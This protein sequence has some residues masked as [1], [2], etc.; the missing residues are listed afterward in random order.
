MGVV[1]IFFIALIFFLLRGPYLSNSIKRLIQP[2][3]ED[4][5]GEKIIIDKAVINLFP[6]YLQT[7]GLK[8]FDEEGNRL[9]WVTKMR[10]Y[11]DVLRL[12]SRE[13]RVRRLTV[14]EPNLTIG[15]ERLEKILDSVRGYAGDDNG[16]NF[17]VSLKAAKITDGEFTLIER[18]RQV[19]ISGSGL[20]I[21]VVVKNTIDVELSVKDVTLK[22]PDLSELDAGF[23][24]RMKLSDKK[25]KIL[26]AKIYSSDSTLETKGEMQ[27]SP[28]GAVEHGT[29]S[30]KASIL[31]KTI[32]EVFG[33]KEKGDGELSFSGSIDLAP[34]FKFNLKTKGWFYLQTLMELLKVK[35]DVTGRMSFDGEI[36]GIYPHVL[37]KGT[38]RLKNALLGGLHLNDVNGELRY[39]DKKFSLEDF[40]AHTYRGKLRGNAF[41]LIPSPHESI[42]TGEYYVDAYAENIDS[43]QF[44]KF[45]KWEPPFPEGK[46]KG[47]FRLNKKPNRRMELVAETTY[48]NTSK[49]GIFLNER[50]G[51]I[52]ADIDMRE[53]ILTFDR[54]I[55]S[56]SASEL[57]LSGSID[58]NKEKLNI[59]IELDSRDALDLTSPYFKGLKAPVKF[60]GKAKGHSKEPEISG[61][62]KVGPG[63][64]NGEPFTE[65]SGD[66]TYSPRSLSVKALRIKYGESVYEIFGSIDFRKTVGLFSFEAPYYRGNAV[67]KNGDAES[68]IAAV[69]KKLPITGFISGRVS[70]E[71]DKEKF[72][73]DVNITLEDSVVFT[74][75][76]DRMVIEAGLSPEKIT[77]SSIEAHRDKS[78]LNARGAVYFDGR[79]DALISSNSINLRDLA[80]LNKYPVGTTRSRVDANFSLDMKGS[81][82]FK[83]PHMKFSIKIS[84][85][86]FKDFLIGE[87]YIEGE[88]KDKRLSAKG[89][90]LIGDSYGKGMIA[91]DAGIFFSDILLWDINMEFK[92]GRYDFLLA[93]FLKDV[94]EDLSASLEGNI[95]LKG[96]KNKFSMDS[97][98]S[99]LSFSLYG[100]S[101]KN[102]GDIVLELTEDTFKIK[103]LSISGRNGDITATGAMKIGQ[104]YNLTIDGRIDLTPLK[105]LTKTIDFLKGDSDFAI[106]IFGHWKSPELKGEINIRDGAVMLA[107]LPYKIGSIDG[108]IFLDKDRITF[109]SF[110]AD[111]AGGRVVASGVGYLEGLSLKRLFVSSEMEGIRFRP[112]EDVDFAFDGK[113]FFET[114]PKRQSLIGDINIKKAKYEK[115]VEWKSWLLRLKEVKEVPLRQPSFLGKTTLN[116]HITGQDNILIDNNVARTPVKVD[117]NVQG[118]LAQY[119]LIGRIEAKGGTVFFR[120]NEFEIIEGSVDFV[121]TNRIVPVFHILAETFTSGYRI[122]LNLDGPA[123]RFALSLFSDPPL[124]E[125]DILALLTTG[126]ISKESKGFES[127]IGA[128]EATAFLTGRLQD[129]MEE[130]FKL[131]TGFERFEVNPQTTTTGAISP[132]ITVGKRLLGEKLFVTYSTSIGTTEEHTIKLQYNLT[133]KFSIIG[134]RDEIGSIGGDVKF[135]FEF[136]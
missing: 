115:R 47:S 96:K 62:I 127:G 81:G 27:L 40:V 3:M 79:F 123:D 18:Q 29:L 33:L 100:Y 109:D 37:G 97:K 46:I 124:S 94:P 84:E 111:F 116:V 68:L 54:A 136:K 126:H 106:E 6:F 48:L 12:F 11:V 4:A 132:R 99:S 114:S 28:E 72:K 80:I 60:I 133:K 135:R 52:K 38:V 59:D 86:Y 87:G 22:L 92:K 19:V 119:G 21:G 113:L 2:A 14:K 34:E 134:S 65:L 78:K 82:T 76:V 130:R 88:L 102:K 56:T 5:I 41:I 58:I 104:N 128:G 108:N 35:E 53:G 95:K 89:D 71:G 25:I 77:I 44:F 85:S 121:E 117:L 16:K 50:L 107:E 7:K 103:S 32:A 118:T 122:R 49:E 67:I 20:Y 17:S 42:P 98:F 51:E 61:S 74:Q 24:G 105:A 57:F 36:H 45:I 112:I 43:H 8:V 26:G 13:I 30:G 23:N 91:A 93:G 15:R 70:F 1:V 39:E 75:P 73:G 101:F 66:I 83:D 110:N 64:I 63:S 9:L 69:Y 10:A 90:F 125:M 131:I 120:N 55:L 31:I 129:V